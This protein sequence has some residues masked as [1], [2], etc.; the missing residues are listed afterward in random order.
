MKKLNKIVK[1]IYDEFDKYCIS[2]YD[3]SASN[4]IN[5]SD[6]KGIIE[7][8][9]NQDMDTHGAVG[10]NLNFYEDCLYFNFSQGYEKINGAV[11]DDYGYVEERM[12]DSGNYTIDQKIAKGHSMALE[13]D[14]AEI[15]SDVLQEYEIYEEQD[16][17]KVLKNI[18]DKEDDYE[19][20]D[21]DKH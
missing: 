15:V 6:I 14:L 4:L 8:L 13:Q 12:G 10:E 16:L 2:N 9:S 5:E 1:D 20:E 7:E 11:E 19:E 3:R 17:E 21:Y 18:E